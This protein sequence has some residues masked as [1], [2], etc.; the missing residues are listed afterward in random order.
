MHIVC[1]DLLCVVCIGLLIAEFS[2]VITGLSRP[3]FLRARYLHRQN[4][5]EVEMAVDDWDY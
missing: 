3:V 5:I 2:A 4:L 1:T